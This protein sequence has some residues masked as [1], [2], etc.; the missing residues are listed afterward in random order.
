VDWAHCI[1]LRAAAD[2]G[3]S[4]ATRKVGKRLRVKNCRK[5]QKNIY[6]EEKA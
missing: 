2:K 1:F 4:F 3:D 5:S 6:H